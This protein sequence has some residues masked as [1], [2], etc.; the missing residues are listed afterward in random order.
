MRSGS[1]AAANR[2]IRNA[3]ISVKSVCTSSQNIFWEFWET[4]WKMVNIVK[5]VLL[6]KHLI[7]MFTWNILFHFMSFICVIFRHSELEYSVIFCCVLFYEIFCVI[8][9]LNIW[10]IPHHSISHI[11]RKYY[12]Y[13]NSTYF[14]ILYTYF[15]QHQF[16]DDHHTFD[17]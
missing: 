3:A 7:N 16:A 12:Y 17:C 2:N 14:T 11:S 10:H 6:L 9:S 5:H 8:F 15:S 4:L 1:V 13:Y